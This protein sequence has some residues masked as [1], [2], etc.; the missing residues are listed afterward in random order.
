MRG[1]R[2]AKLSRFNETCPEFD[3]SRDRND[4]SLE[5]LMWLVEYVLLRRYEG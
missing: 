4:R 2:L 5:T 3:P 1:D